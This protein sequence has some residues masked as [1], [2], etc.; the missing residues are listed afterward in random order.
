[1]S[2]PLKTWHRLGKK[3]FWIFL[4]RHSKFFIVIFG[5]SIWFTYSALFGNLQESYKEFF[6]AFNRKK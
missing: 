4:L 6:V 3:T 1:M 5:L 2:I